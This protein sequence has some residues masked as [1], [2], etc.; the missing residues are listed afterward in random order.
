MIKKISTVMVLII[1]FQYSTAICAE[2][3]K[4]VEI[5]DPTQD[6]VV[7][8]VQL[9]PEINNMVSSWISNVEGFYGK[10][11]PI[12]DDGYAIKVP[13]DSDVKVETECLNTIINEVYIIIPEYQ[14]P[15]FLVFENEDK[16]SCFSFNGDIDELSKVLD[17]KLK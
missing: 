9:N 3:F 16:V 10:I 6:K 2:E 15:F 4:Y 17:F 7:K 8:V 11:D 5:F 12:T 13:L 1:I 14:A